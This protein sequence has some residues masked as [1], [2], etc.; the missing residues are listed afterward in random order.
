MTLILTGVI[1]L[2]I[3]SSKQ[4]VL[5]ELR[6]QVNIWK[7]NSLTALKTCIYMQLQT[8]SLFYSVKKYVCIH[9][10]GEK[11]LSSCC[12]PPLIATITRDKRLFFLG[13]YYD[14]YQNWSV[15]Y[16]IR[17]PNKVNEP[18]CGIR[19]PQDS[20]TAQSGPLII[21]AVP[22]LKQAEFVLWN[23]SISH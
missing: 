7:N 12:H 5:T 19:C 17:S 13:P 20:K 10:K 18:T 4:I 9:F 16:S 2:D 21:K 22:W 8:R 23:Q 15:P 3:L 14:I 6:D 1:H 11:C